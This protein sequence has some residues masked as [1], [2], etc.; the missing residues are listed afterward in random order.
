[1]ELTRDERALLDS[2]KRHFPYPVLGGWYT[3]VE[4]E[5]LTR[6]LRES[7]D[8]KVGFHGPEIKQ[9]EQE[10]AAY[11]NVKHAIAVNSCGTGLDAAMQ[12]LKLGPGDEVIVPAITYMATALCVL[13]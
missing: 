3:E 8:W 11:C 2:G 9:F 5:A 4:F 10:F 12:A 1:M 7:M 13:G 6:A